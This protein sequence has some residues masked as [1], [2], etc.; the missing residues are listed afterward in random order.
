MNPPHPRPKYNPDAVLADFKMCMPALL[1]L[2]FTCA[3]Y[4]KKKKANQLSHV[5]ED[6]PHYLKK[7]EKEEKKNPKRK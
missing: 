1:G 7:K 2:V 5:T 6:F 4:F 3:H